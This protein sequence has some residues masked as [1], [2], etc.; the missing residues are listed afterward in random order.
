MFGRSKEASTLQRKVEDQSSRLGEY[1]DVLRAI[2]AQLDIND[3]AAPGLVDPL[4]A[5]NKIMAALQQRAP[6]NDQPAE[7]GV[8]QRPITAKVH[9]ID[10]AGSMEVVIALGDTPNLELQCDDK[11]FLKKVLTAIKG[12]T[13]TLS[14]EPTMIVSSRQSKKGGQVTTQVFHGPV[15]SVA[16][17]DIF[18]GRGSQVNAVDGAV[19]VSGKGNIV[20]RN[21]HGQHISGDVTVHGT[22]YFGGKSSGGAM[23]IFQSGSTPVVKVRLT[24]PQVTHLVISGSG[25]MIFGN[26]QQTDLSIQILGSGAVDVAGVVDELEVDVSGSGV[27]AARSLCAKKAWIAISG[28]G[29]VDATVSEA[30]E[31]NVAGS[32]RIKIAGNPPQRETNVSGSGKIKFVSDKSQA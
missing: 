10:L 5:K 26:C 22:Q 1:S 11:A 31:A 25:N 24:L 17:G 21:L 6:A 23:Q 9:R 3:F 19:Q 4:R 29:E 28:S 8:E 30:V 12:D 15:D 14:T 7:P 18:V 27:V 16:G 32:G 2:A 20:I 13:L